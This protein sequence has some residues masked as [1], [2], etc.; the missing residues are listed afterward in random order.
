MKQD[1]WWWYV[2]PSAA[3]N[4]GGVEFWYLTWGVIACSQSKR[5]SP[6]EIRQKSIFVCKLEWRSLWGLWESCLFWIRLISGILFDSHKL[7]SFICWW[8]K[9]KTIKLN[10]PFFKSSKTPKRPQL[11]GGRCGLS[12]LN[13]EQKAWGKRGSLLPFSCVFKPAYFV[14]W[15]L[16]SGVLWHLGLS[17]NGIHALRFWR[18]LHAHYVYKSLCV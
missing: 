16:K 8:K 13:T 7:L 10:G 4:L 11:L 3:G 2:P 15:A 9:L 5:Q 6:G 12:A 18:F 17:T 1:C 14:R